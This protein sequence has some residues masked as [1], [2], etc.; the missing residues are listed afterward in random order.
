MK[1]RLIQITL[2]GLVASSFSL[3]AGPAS[4][5]GT[6]ATKV[7]GIQAFDLGGACGLTPP[8]DLPPGLVPAVPFVMTGSLVGCWWD[9]VA[10]FSSQP[11]GTVQEAGDEVFIGCV[12]LDGDGGCAGDP[13]GAFS[14]TFTFT[15]KF[16]P[17]T[18]AEVHG[19]CHH[20][21]VSGTGAFARATGEIQFT[22]DVAN[23]TSPYHGEVKY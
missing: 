11:S 2:A 3:G 10:S 6:G 1:I 20:T 22:D 16:D 4:A 5:S 13:T 19:R 23:G 14:L 8:A 15:G 12:D 17:A 18:G 9:S 21:I 7:T